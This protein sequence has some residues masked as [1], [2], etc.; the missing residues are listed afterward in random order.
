[1][2]SRRERLLSG[3]EIRIEEETSYFELWTLVKMTRKVARFKPGSQVDM[4][5]V[6][7]TGVDVLDLDESDRRPDTF[8]RQSEEVMR[9][10]LS[11]RRTSKRPTSGSQGDSNRFSFIQGTT[12]SDGRFA[13]GFS[14]EQPVVEWKAVDGTLDFVRQHYYVDSEEWEGAM[15]NYVVD[16]E[17]NKIIGETKCNYIG[18]RSS[19]NHR[20]CHTVWSQNNRFMVQHFHGKW[21]TIKAT[22]VRIDHNSRSLVAIDLMEPIKEHAFEF[23]RRTKDRAFRKFGFERFA[24]SFACEKISNTGFLTFRVFG[25]IP[26]FGDEDG[27]FSIIQRVRI[28]EGSGGVSLRFL[29]SQSGPRLS[30]S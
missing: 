26:K 22:I 8:Q 19:F 6:R 7:G 16:V 29:D 4:T 5:G 30:Y 17:T 2:I 15:T 27:T 13:L 12:S 10:L 28:L 3:E 14:L 9:A 18:T 11:K 24:V 23:L 25:E 20:A 21:H 1:V